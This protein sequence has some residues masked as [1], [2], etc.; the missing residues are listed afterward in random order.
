MCIRDRDIRVNYGELT[1]KGVQDALVTVDFGPEA[2]I[3]AVYTPTELSLIH[4]STTYHHSAIAM[5]KMMFQL[6]PI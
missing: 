2:T 5:Q 1:K 4:I 6:F 3:M